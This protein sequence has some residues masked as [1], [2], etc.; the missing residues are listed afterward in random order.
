MGSSAI[1]I[2]KFVGK[3]DAT[4]FLIVLNMLLLR[5]GDKIPLVVSLYMC[6]GRELRT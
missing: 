5:E 6:E 2:A 3:S 1:T 4:L